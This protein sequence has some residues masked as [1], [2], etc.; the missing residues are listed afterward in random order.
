VGGDRSAEALPEGLELQRVRAGPSFGE[1]GGQSKGH[2]KDSDEC[3]VRRPHRPDRL[4]R[5]DC[6]ALDHAAIF[7]PE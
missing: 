2:A 6:D 3:T 7:S 1:V 5:Q 4:K